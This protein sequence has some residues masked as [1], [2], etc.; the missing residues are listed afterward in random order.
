MG[1]VEFKN[2]AGYETWVSMEVLNKGYSLETKYIVL[3]NKNNKYLLRVCDIKNYDEK[4]LQFDLL[5]EIAKV[6]VNAP[7]AISFGKLNEEQVYTLLTWLEGEDA[8]D[9]IAKL[10]DKKAYNLGIEAGKSLYKLHQIP[11]DTKNQKP[12]AEKFRQKMDRKYKAMDEIDIKIDNKEL[13]IKYIKEHIHLLD[14]RVQTFTHGD[15]H[16]NNL[17]VNEGKIGVIDFEKNKVADPYDDFKPFMWN[18]FVSEY[19]ETG[20]ING[21]FNNSIPEDFFPILAV[22]AVE[23][24]V[25]FLPWAYKM[26]GDNL[27]TAYKINESIMKWYKNLTITIPTWYKG[28]LNFDD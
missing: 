10:S 8:A 20:F 19:F 14:N 5:L 11:V 4:K 13:M 16:L 26:G 12:W 1:F 22:Y 3:D 21:Y 25:S 7:R 23:N 15:Y 18:V 17:I 9:A 27:K 6:G 24:L 28:I 2:V